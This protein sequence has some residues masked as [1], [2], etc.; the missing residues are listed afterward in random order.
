MPEYLSWQRLPL[1]SREPCTLLQLTDLHLCAEPDAELLGVP[2]DASFLSVLSKATKDHPDAAACL[3]TG[4]LS[5]DGSPEAYRRLSAHCAE[6][7]PWPA[8]WLPGN[9]DQNPALRDAA[10]DGLAG[11]RCLVAGAWRVILLDSS[12]PNEVGGTLGEAEYR[13]LELALMDSSDSPVL[14]VLHHPPADCGTRWL[15]AQQLSDG[16]RFWAMLARH[17]NVKAVLCGHIHQEVDRVENGVRL[18]ASPSTC[19]QFMPGA[20]HFR[21]QESTPGY[22][23][24]R[25]QPD[26]SLQ[27]GVERL[28]AGSFPAHFD[29]TDGY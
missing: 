2:T 25:L 17:P 23:W 8:V 22:R 5:D 21:L 11:S 24:L 14:V 10:G 3:L 7:L 9:H 12:V 20:D 4:D 18:L 6:G 26:G 1:D 13:H 16:E 15:D 19:V 28:P 27:T 29:N